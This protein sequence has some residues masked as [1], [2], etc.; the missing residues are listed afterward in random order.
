[1]SARKWMIVAL[2]AF[3]ACSSFKRLERHDI[4]VSESEVLAAGKSAD[5]TLLPHLRHIV[6]NPSNYDTAVL[7]ATIVAL[8]ERRDAGAVPSLA[9]LTN[10]SRE[11]VRWQVARTLA[12]IGTSASQSVLVTIANHDTSD[13]VREEA[14][15]LLEH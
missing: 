11:E 10:D 8:G 12:A 14:H 9:T 6:A 5:P 13:F 15:A 3:A 7:V 2:T 4:G 1:M